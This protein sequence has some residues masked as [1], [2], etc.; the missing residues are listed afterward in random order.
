[1]KNRS[2]AKY[3]I[4]LYEA[5][6]DQQHDES[7]KPF[8]KQLKRETD[9]DDLGHDALFSY[10]V[11]AG[12]ESLLEALNY[13]Q[14]VGSDGRFKIGYFAVHGQHDNL[15]ALSTIGK[16][17]LRNI[18]VKTSNFDGLFFGACDFVNR[19]TATLLLDS[20][21]SL[22]WV[23][24]YEKWTPWLEG[25]ISDIMFFRLLFAGR[26]KR[27][28][29]RNTR[30][31]KIHKPEDA[32]KML[33]EMYPIS[34]DLKFSLYYRGPNGINSTLDEWETKCMVL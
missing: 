14:D 31:E 28:A 3:I 2:E 17:K 13:K 7:V 8:F 21:S 32:A 19:K 22:K 18:L 16:L 33:Y 24:G 34:T 12:A 15:Q 6:W 27:P 1:M 9:E 26:F 11:F 4:K 29:K 5:Q 30:W 10:Y 25:T 23:A 20:I